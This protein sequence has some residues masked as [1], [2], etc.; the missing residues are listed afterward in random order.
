[1]SALSLL[2]SGGSKEQRWIERPS[3]PQVTRLV[4]YNRV[5][6][7]KSG[8]RGGFF[9]LADYVESGYYPPGTLIFEIPC[10][11]IQPLLDWHVAWEKTT[12]SLG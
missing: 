12:D 9:D 2:L 6:S 5:E 7:R 3:L 8:G 4:G 1:M 10:T 11:S